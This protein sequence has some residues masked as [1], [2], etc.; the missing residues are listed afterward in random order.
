[1]S[2]DPSYCLILAANWHRI[3]LKNIKWRL[4]ILF[5]VWC[6]IQAI[7]CYVFIPETKNRTL[8]EL[9]DIF[10]DPRPVKAS[11]VKKKLAADSHGNIL[12]VEKI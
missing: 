9:D 11:L 6:P 5:A 2:Q 4:Y 3:A 1:V 8:E 12:E 10:N 7:V